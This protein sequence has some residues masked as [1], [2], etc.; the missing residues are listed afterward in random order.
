MPKLMISEKLLTNTLAS[1]STPHRTRASRR[2]KK[3]QWAQ[4]AR[5]IST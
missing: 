3:A 5:N 1:M 4:K 2:V